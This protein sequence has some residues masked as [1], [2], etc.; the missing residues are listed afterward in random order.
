MFRWPGKSK[1]SNNPRRTDNYPTIPGKFSN[2]VPVSRLDACDMLP[3]LALWTDVLRCCTISSV[4][5]F[6]RSEINCFAIY[7]Q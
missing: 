4:D 5:G 7:F 6:S 1:S 2:L 3:I